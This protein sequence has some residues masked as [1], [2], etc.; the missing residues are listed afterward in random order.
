MN[1]LTKLGILGWLLCISCSL[2]AQ[3]ADTTSCYKELE[4]EGLAYLE[5]NKYNLA[6]N[7]FF[8]AYRCTDRP[9][10]HKIDDHMQAVINKLKGIAKVAQNAAIAAE[11]AKTEAEAARQAEAAAKKEAQDNADEATRIAQQAESLRLALL[12]DLER[13]KQAYQTALQLAYL[14]LKLSDNDNYD[15][16]FSTFSKVVRD[17]F[18]QPLPVGSNLKN[19][20]SHAGYLLV[21]N[22]LGLTIWEEATWTPIAHLPDVENYTPVPH[23]A[24]FLFNTTGS[25]TLN[26]YIIPEQQ[27]VA[28]N[29]QHGERLTYAST[30]Q[31]GYLTSSR[32]DN[33]ILW[34]KQGRIL[35]TLA[36]HDG[37]IYE[38]LYCGANNSIIT[39]SSDGK[40]K[41]WSE[42]GEWISDLAQDYYFHDIELN[43]Q[44]D[45]LAAATATGQ[46]LLWK[47]SSLDEQAQILQHGSTPVNKVRIFPTEENVLVSHDIK[48]QLKIWQ[49][50][51]T[52]DP[53]PI[54][55]L[56]TVQD[57]I[58]LENPS[59]ILAWT[60]AGK[61]YVIDQNGQIKNSWSVPEGN[62]NG[63]AY[64]PSID[65]FLSTSEK[66]NQ[67]IRWWSREGEQHL[68]WETTVMPDK[69]WH[70]LFSTH[71]H[72][73]II[74]NLT[75]ELVNVY[76][77]PSEKLAELEQQTDF[78]NR[79]L[80]Q[81]FNIQ[82]WPKD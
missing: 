25:N 76:P 9:R 49:L 77:L 13:E 20:Q 71:Q 17:S 51:Q 65:G 10:D 66:D 56:P 39:R 31:Y 34:N 8:S 61:C 67:Y 4:A 62:I 7:S 32:D 64:A 14:S 24:Q 54:P 2:P 55:G 27:Q 75:N 18:A 46:I 28:L 80:L 30:N 53:V 21:Q 11:K 57:F 16:A 1:L 48:G 42:Q 47:G 63:M 79:E 44:G 35:T 15:N 26:M 52:S 43:Q 37:N 38:H 82:V 69:K 73:V 72:Y 3:E 58:L 22:E 68:Q 36:G 81:A 45:L 40:L 19:I 29:A 41:Y 59:D 5:D 6:I 74:P 50:R 78:I 70:G 12:A 33:S 23:L 60:K